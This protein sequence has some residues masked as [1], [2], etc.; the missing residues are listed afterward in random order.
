MQKNY[1]ELFGLEPNFFVNDVELNSTLK[2]LLHATHPDRYASA[3]SQEQMI[4]MQKT[5]EIND[6]YAILKNPV[7]RAQYLLAIK[8]G[9]DVSRNVTVND[10]VFLMQQL[11]LREQLE[12]IVLRKNASELISFSD[13]IESIRDEQIAELKLFFEQNEW[14]IQNIQTAIYKLQFLLKTLHDIEV[15][16][17]R[18]LD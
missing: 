16:E 13:H 11:E 6:A 2:K 5:T 12:H 7:R 1:F 18:L 9:V 10:P 15:A 8:K 17:D 14:S 3:S 4:A